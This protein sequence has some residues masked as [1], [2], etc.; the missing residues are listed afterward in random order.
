VT[1]TPDRHKRFCAMWEAGVP[2]VEIAAAFETTD[3][4]VRGRAR[5]HRLTPRQCERY[6][7]YRLKP[8]TQAATPWEVLPLPPEPPLASLPPDDQRYW[9]WKRARDGARE[10]LRA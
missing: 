5:Y 9:I 1:W 2:S 6:G 7:A 8:Q 3:D 10:A 4:A